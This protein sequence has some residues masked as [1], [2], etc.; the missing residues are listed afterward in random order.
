MRRIWFPIVLVCSSC[1]PGGGGGP[2]GGSGGGGGGGGGG[3]SSA[4]E[5]K[6]GSLT[7]ESTRYTV[8]TTEVEQGY[9][10]GTFYRIPPATGSGGGGCHSS[11]YGACDVQSCVFGGTASD[12][13]VSITYTDAGPLTISG[14]LV[15]NGT[16]TL[17]PGAY[18]YDTVSG[19]VALF[20]GGDTVHFVASGNA[21]GAPAFD[22]QLVAPS[23]VQVSAPDFVQGKV[24]ASANHDLAVAWTGS[25]A[26]NVTVQLAAGTSG[27]SAVARCTFAGNSGGGVVP[28]AAIAA[29]GSAGGSASILVMSE[30]RTTRNPDGWSIAFSLQSY[31]ILPSGLAAGTLEIQ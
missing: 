7:I 13:G 17:T 18:G 23:S 1:G 2:D 25:S 5:T 31:G 21:N 19:A 20:D 6:S 4:T 26:A 22:V 11:T 14:V 15:N 12:G 8:S 24:V 9:A 16:M 27:T 3:G 29:V 30:S 28:A 10:T